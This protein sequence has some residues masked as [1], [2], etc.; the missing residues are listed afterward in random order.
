MKIKQFKP[1][2]GIEELASVKECFDSKWITEGPKSKE[3]CSKL[4]EL[5]SAKYGVFANNGTL[6]LY[7]GLK[8]LG[9][10]EGD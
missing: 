8:A 2:L 10:K 5:M 7:L 9:I 4:L 6:S 3:F 1:F